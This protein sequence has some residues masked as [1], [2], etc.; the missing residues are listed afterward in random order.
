MAARSASLLRRRP[1]YRDRLPRGPPRCPA[2]HFPSTPRPE[3]S[4][5]PPTRPIGLTSPSRSS[6]VTAA[7]GTHR[8]PSRLLSARLVSVP[9]TTLL[10][11]DRTHCQIRRAP[12]MSPS[13]RRETSLFRPSTASPAA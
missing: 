5:T 10:P 13:A 12:A 3:N 9:N 8:Q 1:E 4:L 6:Q 7:L 11:P 2:V